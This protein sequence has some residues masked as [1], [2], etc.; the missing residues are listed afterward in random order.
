MGDATIEFKSGDE[1]IKYC[2]HN[3]LKNHP[4]FQNEANYDLAHLWA[5]TKIG[6]TYK[7]QDPIWISHICSKITD[8]ELRCFLIADL[9]DDLGHGDYDHRQEL[10]LQSMG[11]TL[12]PWAFADKKTMLEAEDKQFAARLHELKMHDD[13]RIS[14][15]AVLAGFMFG[16][17]IIDYIFKTLRLNKDK[18]THVKFDEWFHGGH[19]HGGEAQTTG[20]QDDS[21]KIARSIT[22]TKTPEDL[23]QIVLGVKAAEKIYREMFDLLNGLKS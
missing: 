19:Y 22:N 15:G 16:E 1:L 13:V 20:H 4:F 9:N 12:E 3:S 10:V 11:E 6:K 21:M 18:L 5:L 7:N 17:V 14:L 23:K 2:L 8:A